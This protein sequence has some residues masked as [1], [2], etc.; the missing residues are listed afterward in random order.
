[1]QWFFGSILKKESEMVTYR[2]LLRILND[3]SAEE[4]DQTATVYLTAEDEYVPVSS[5]LV[6]DGSDDVLDVGHVYF[7]V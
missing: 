6:E 2:N 4:L 5:V 1:L 7:S 3:M